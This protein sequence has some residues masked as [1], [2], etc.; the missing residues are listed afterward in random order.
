M[1]FFM[2]NY[3][4]CNHVEQMHDQISPCSCECTFLFYA[5]NPIN[6]H[7]FHGI[8]TEWFHQDPSMHSMK[9][10]INQT[11]YTLTPRTQ[12]FCSH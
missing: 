10:T 11:E 6:V 9:S 7:I 4:S 2:D 1:V 8:M 3:M 5:Q 12:L